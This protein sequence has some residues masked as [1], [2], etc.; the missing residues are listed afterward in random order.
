AAVA[1]SADGNSVYVAGKSANAVT[2]FST[3]CG[4]GNVDPGEQCD[5]GN[6]SDGDGCSAG[7]RRECA[8]APDC[9]DADLC[10]EMHC[11]NDECA[12]PRCGL[13]GGM[14]ELRDAERWRADLA[15]RPPLRP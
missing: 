9:N 8:V 10:T 11:I 13:D 5:D 7:C 2:T 4:D 3:R 14:C 12:L 1:V 6:A 15:A